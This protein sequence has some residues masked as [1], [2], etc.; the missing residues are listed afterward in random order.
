MPAPK[1]QNKQEVIRW[2]KEGL[3]YEEM[4]QKYMELYNIETVPSLWG[5]FRRREGLPKRQARDTSLIPWKVKPEHRFSYDLA[6][7]RVEARKRQEFEVRE[8]DLKRLESWRKDLDEANAVVHYDPGHPEG[9]NWVPREP[10]DKDI[11]RQPP[12]ELRTGRRSAD[13]GD[14]PGDTK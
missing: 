8:T 7:L 9:F 13:D 5:N 11:I 10:T 4:C 2:F 12:P 3:T 6:M 1:I 14:T